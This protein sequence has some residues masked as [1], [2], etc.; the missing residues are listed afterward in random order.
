MEYCG[1]LAWIMK[2]KT[3]KKVVGNPVAEVHS[4]DLSVDGKFKKSVYRNSVRGSCLES[5]GSKQI[6][7]EICIKRQ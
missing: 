3:Y 2:M 5:A 6:Q 4:K 7:M 1:K